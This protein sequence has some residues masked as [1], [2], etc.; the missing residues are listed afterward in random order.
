MRSLSRRALL[1]GW[2]IGSAVWC[3]GCRGSATVQ[4]V[5]LH[6]SEIDPPS[7][8][9]TRFDAPEAYWWIDQAGEINVAVRCLKRN[10]WLGRLGDAELAFSLTPGPPPAG[11]ARN[12]KIALRESRILIRSGWRVQRF[13]AFAGILGLILDDETHAHG[14]FRVWLQPQAQ[15]SLFAF[16]PQPPGSVM[17]FGTFKAVRDAFRGEEI[18]AT[19]EADGWTRPTRRPSATTR[20]RTTEP[21]TGR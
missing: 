2:A 12:Y 3:M 6:P 15:L 10:V 8:E 19:C 1:A 9:V 21:S 4:F 18:R 11:R 5:A 16:P 17:C 14:S 13:T 7:T 20:P